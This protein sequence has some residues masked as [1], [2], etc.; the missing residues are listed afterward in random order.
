MPDQGAELG[1]DLYWLSTVANDDLPTVA[2]V[3]H[4]AS[5]HVASAGRP[6]SGLMARAGAFGGGTS[7][8]FAAWD[9]LWATTTKFIG[10]TGTNLDD[11]A[12]ALNLAIDHYVHTDGTVKASFD[13]MNLQNGVPH[14]DPAK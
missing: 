2:N 3:F 10:D 4:D 5:G 7:S 9:E 14:A 13:G 8:I 1:V 12:H 6:V 11:T